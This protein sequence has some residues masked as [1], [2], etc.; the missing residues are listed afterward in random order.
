MMAHELL[1]QAALILT[2]GW[3]KNAGARDDADRIVPLWVE[4]LRQA[5]LILGGWCKD[6]DARDNAGPHSSA[7]GRRGPVGPVL[8]F[9]PCQADRAGGHAIRH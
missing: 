9:R 3:S 8:G 6:A 5:A 2:D 1:R 4:L 7:V